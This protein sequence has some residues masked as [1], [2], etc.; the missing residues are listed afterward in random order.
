MGIGVKPRHP[1]MLWY[2]WATFSVQ[3][4]RLEFNSEHDLVTSSLAQRNKDVGHAKSFLTKRPLVVAS[5]MTEWWW[6]RERM[7][8]S[9]GWRS[10][11]QVV[12]GLEKPQKNGW[13]TSRVI[14]SPRILL[15][16]PRDDYQGFCSDS[17]ADFNCVVCDS[18]CP[19]VY[20]WHF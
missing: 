5:P 9:S 2:Y 14:H 11:T 17:H 1:L 8:W 3:S 13:E 18:G 4:S 19:M 12:L 15:F 16:F 20:P 6:E 7:R 10:H